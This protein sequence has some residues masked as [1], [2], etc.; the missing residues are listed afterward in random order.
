MSDDL[1]CSGVRNE[2]RLLAAIPADVKELAVGPRYD[3]RLRRLTNPLRFEDNPIT[4]L[5]HG[6]PPNLG[7]RVGMILALP[8][9]PYGPVS[10]GGFASLHSFPSQRPT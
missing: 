5:N 4:D 6:V 10:Q 7:L 2:R 3:P 9:K 8:R 1:E